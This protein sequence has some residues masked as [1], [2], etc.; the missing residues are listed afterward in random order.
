MRREKTKTGEPMD[1]RVDNRTSG[2][3][4]NGTRW[5][6]AGA[7]ALFLLAGIALGVVADRLLLLP[8]AAEA[9]PLT[10]EAMVSH[11]ELDATQETHLRALLDSLHA[12][13]MAVVE[14]HPDSLPAA[15]RRAHLR[16]ESA[17]PP[18]ARDE[19]RAWMQGHHHQM[20]GRIR[21]DMGG[22]YMPGGNMR[23][24]HMRD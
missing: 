16:I 8:R 19:F 24:G 11:L 13:M 9:Q 3:R 2:T 5:R 1:N 18:E 17:L 23:G 7:A 12:E 10:A 20:M 6:A 14:R 15:A 22:G 21:G 4:S